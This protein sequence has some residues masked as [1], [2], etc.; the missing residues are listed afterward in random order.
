MTL[1]IEN[2][3]TRAA[4]I[5]QA[6]LVLAKES[7]LV[8]ASWLRLDCTAMASKGYATAVGVK[9]ALAYVSDGDGF[10]FTIMGDYQSEGRNAISNCSK[11][12]PVTADQAQIEAIVQKFAAEV[13][14]AVAETYAAKLL[15]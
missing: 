15:K 8:N 11:L 10:N 6:K 14:A 7:W 3:C 4:L 2:K 13:D 5:A 9:A 1:N 12:V